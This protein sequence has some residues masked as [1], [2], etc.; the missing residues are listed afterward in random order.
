MENAKVDSSN[1]IIPFTRYEDKGIRKTAFFHLGKLRTPE[2]FINIFISGLQDKSSQV[3]DT[4]IQALSDIA[5][6]KLLKYYKQ[7]ALKYP[8][9]TDYILCNL[10]HN[11]KAYNLS[12]DKIRSISYEELENFPPTKWYQF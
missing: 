1:F 9:E 8:K 5:N 4:T 7:V 12:L 2:R 3:V 11:L 10:K 6:K